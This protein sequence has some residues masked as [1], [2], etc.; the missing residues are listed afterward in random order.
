MW[1]AK[2]KSIPWAWSSWAP[3]VPEDPLQPQMPTQKGWGSSRCDVSQLCA[4][5]VD[6]S[7]N[8]VL[9][10]PGWLTWGH[11]SVMKFLPLFWGRTESKMLF[12]NAATTGKNKVKA[13]LLRFSKSRLASESCPCLIAAG[14][15]GE[16]AGS[17]SAFVSTTVQHLPP[18][19]CMHC[20][21]NKLQGQRG[22]SSKNNSF[23]H[24]L[25]HTRPFPEGSSRS[26]MMAQW[27][28]RPVE[29]QGL[30]SPKG[31][32]STKGCWNPEG[33]VSASNW[34]RPS[35]RLWH[36][37]Q[38]DPSAE[39]REVKGRS[40]GLPWWVTVRQPLPS[41]RAEA[42]LED[43]AGQNTPSH[44]CLLPLLPLQLARNSL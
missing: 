24:R 1:D 9:A 6:I 12:L 8:T 33:P 37:S 28:Q 21:P 18:Q 16:N 32:L 25:C 11:W 3:C 36:L 40:T 4:N 19:P 2:P 15:I 5:I 30:L 26:P 17:C 38:H 39:V 42:E 20:C 7:G 27:G 22:W 23:H 29:P 31:L 44:P 43:G 13:E 35:W 41:P 34:S 10:A 14:Q